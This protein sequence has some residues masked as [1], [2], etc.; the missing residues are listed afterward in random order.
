VVR[1]TVVHELRSVLCWLGEEFSI[2]TRVIAVM[3]V[4]GM[5]S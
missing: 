4:R 3:A 2:D 1:A 5:L